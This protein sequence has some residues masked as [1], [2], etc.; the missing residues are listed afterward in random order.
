MHALLG[1]KSAFTKAAC[2]TEPNYPPKFPPLHAEPRGLDDSREVPHFVLEAH[3]LRPPG[4]ADPVLG[5]LVG[6]M[7]RV[8]DDGHA[9]PGLRR[10][11][12]E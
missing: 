9:L 5:S 11:V 12:N 6:L 3:R 4:R 10:R 8:A 2:R 7:P 1:S